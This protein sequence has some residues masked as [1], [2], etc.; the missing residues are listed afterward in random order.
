MQGRPRQFDQP[1]SGAERA[2]IHRK[3]KADR[4]RHTAGLI[5]ELLAA[6][7][8]DVAARLIADDRYKDIITAALLR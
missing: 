2:R 5:A 4:E 1:L 3:R 6:A 7:P 8:E